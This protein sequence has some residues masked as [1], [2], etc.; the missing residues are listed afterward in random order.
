MFALLLSEVAI[1]TSFTISSRADATPVVMTQ[2][3]NVYHPDSEKTF[4]VNNDLF[5][6]KPYLI[7]ATG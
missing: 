5:T 6:F 1:A 2:T 7:I 4:A 3:V